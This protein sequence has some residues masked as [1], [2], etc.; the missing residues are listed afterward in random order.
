MN[1]DSSSLGKI[2]E[3]AELVISTIL[4]GYRIQLTY[5]LAGIQ[6]MDGYLDRLHMNFPPDK[7]SG[8][9]EVLGS[10]VGECIIS[11]YGGVWI[12]KDTG[13]G[14]QINER[15]WVAPFNKVYKQ[16]ENGPEDSVA[17]FFTLI[18]L[19][20]KMPFHKTDH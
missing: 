8:P 4:K 17:S 3:N 15:V 1:E 7:R 11:T 6:W 18:P 19:I 9:V 16:L 20:D 14:I 12:R 2:R 5:D 10:F 13:L